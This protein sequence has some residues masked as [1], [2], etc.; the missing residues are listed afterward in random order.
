VTSHSLNVETVAIVAGL[1][2]GGGVWV[3][4]VDPWLDQRRQHRVLRRRQH[5]DDLLA[6]RNRTG[7]HR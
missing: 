4:V 6:R 1:F 7:A 5:Q 3:V 2:G